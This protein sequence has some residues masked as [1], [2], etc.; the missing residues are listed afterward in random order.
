M[1][2]TEPIQVFIKVIF[3]EC[4]KIEDITGG[5]RRCQAHGGEARALID[6]PCE[7]LPKGQTPVTSVSQSLSESRLS[8]QVVEG[9]DG[10]NRQSLTDHNVAIEIA[11]LGKV[12]L[13][14]QGEANRLD[15]F[16][17]TA[18]DVSDSAMF[19]F[20]VVAEGLP[21]EVSGVGFA[22]GTESRGVD[23][24]SGYLIEQ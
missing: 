6:D 3:I 20:A 16:L 2:I 4:F 12:V 24:H 5:M 10:A 17:G 8:S 18:R 15:F 7:D 22:L 11:H 23:I 9:P 1:L 13:V 14:A 19:N 21:K